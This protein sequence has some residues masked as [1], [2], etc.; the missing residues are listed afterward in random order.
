MADELEVVDAPEVSEVVAESVDGEPELQFHTVESRP[1]RPIYDDVLQVGRELERIL[2]QYGVNARK[3]NSAVDDLLKQVI[4]PIILNEVPQPVR[5]N[6]QQFIRHQLTQVPLAEEYKAWLLP[7][8]IARCVVEAMLPSMANLLAERI[9]PELL[10]EWDVTFDNMGLP[11][12][13]GEVAVMLSEVVA[14]LAPRYRELWGLPPEAAGEVDDVQGDAVDV[15]QVEQPVPDFDALADGDDSE[16]AAG[17]AT[18][19]PAE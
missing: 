17:D 8:T 15:A 12:T 19:L 2:G 10:A 13:Q 5:V 7:R 4:F 3:R 1:D 18:E 6:A 11:L 9:T 14:G 16:C